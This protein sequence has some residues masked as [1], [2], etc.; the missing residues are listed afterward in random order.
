MAGLGRVVV[1]FV[2]QDYGNRIGHT[3]NRVGG[4][5]VSCGRDVYFNASGAAAVRDRDAHPICER[6]H[7]VHGDEILRKEI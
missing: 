3:A 2:K 5:C 7:K 4:P 1:G 6:C